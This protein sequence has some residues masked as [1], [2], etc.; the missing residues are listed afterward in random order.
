LPPRSVVTSLAIAALFVVFGFPLFSTF[1][2]RT[3]PAAHGG[4]VLG[5]L[6]LATA[7]SAA[8][9]AHER[10]SLGFRLVGALGAALVVGFAFRHGGSS[11]LA[12]GDLL[13]LASIATSALGYT[14]SGRLS[15]SMPGWEVICWGWC[16][17]CRS[18]SS[19]RSYSGRRIPPPCRRRRG[20][21]FSRRRLSASCSA[22]F[23]WNARLALGGIARVS[24][25]QLLQP[26]VIVALAAPINGE[27][28]D[29]ETLLFA[30]AVV[31][32]VA[33]GRAMQVKRLEV[34][35]Q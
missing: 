15:L 30:A 21:R 17:R 27:T 34:A 11:S 33:V 13:L 22:F 19:A 31:G 2:M 16:Y 7:A 29:L 23:A 3:V 18:Q 20:W 10:A 26:F 32:T 35:E 25:V 28:I 4:V 24:Q 6:P 9:L 1:A 5:I 8:V 12:V 14:L